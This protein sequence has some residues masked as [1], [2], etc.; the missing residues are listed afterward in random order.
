MLAGADLERIARRSALEVDDTARTY[1]EE[2]RKII[3]GRLYGMQPRPRSYSHGTF[4]KYIDG[5]RCDPCVSVAAQKR[6]RQAK[7]ANSETLETAT[8]HYKQWTGPELEIAARADLTARQVAVML[9]RTLKS[10]KGI[11]VKL[12]DD[13][14]YRDTAGVL[15][16]TP[17]IIGK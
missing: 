15:P 16:G 13:P 1:L 3:L 7:R 4:M 2:A 17:R 8:N 9:G 12:R 11:R 14:R 6:N 10:V 5:C